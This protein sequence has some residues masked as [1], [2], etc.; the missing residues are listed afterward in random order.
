LEVNMDINKLA[1]VMANFDH[2]L[3]TTLGN[4]L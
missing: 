4:K 1:E 3:D 2:V